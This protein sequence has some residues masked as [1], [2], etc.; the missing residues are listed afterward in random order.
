MPG[1]AGVIR[2]ITGGDMQNP[3]ERMAIIRRIQAWIIIRIVLFPIEENR[4]GIKVL[5]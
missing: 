1:S 3:W 2:L 5:K 4:E